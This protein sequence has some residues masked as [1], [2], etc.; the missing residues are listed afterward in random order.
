MDNLHGLI[1]SLTI[2]EFEA[3]RNSYL[4]QEKNNPQVQKTLS[5]LDFLRHLKDVPSKK[6]CIKHVY[7]TSKEDSFR[8]LKSR[9]NQRIL[10]ILIHENNIDK[11]EIEEL[12]IVTIRLRKKFSQV[13]YLYFT[14]GNLPVVYNLLNS[15]I[16]SAEE[17]NI[18]SI[19]I[20][21]LRL[22]KQFVSIRET[23]DVMEEFDNQ[24]SYYQRCDEARH[25]AVDFYCRLVRKV[26]FEGGEKKDKIQALLLDGINEL[27]QLYQE[28]NAPV[29]GYYLKILELA[30]FSNSKNYS[31]AKESCM[32]QLEFLQSKELYRKSRVGMVYD[33]AGQLQILTGNYQE[34][35]EYF[36][37][38]VKHY[39]S[40]SINVV[41]SREQEFFAQFYMGDYNAAM[42]TIS[43]L[44]SKNSDDQGNFRASKFLYY[45]A[46][47]LFQSGDFQQCK[48]IIMQN[49][50]LN[51]DKAGWEVAVRILSIMSNIELGNFDMAS[52]QIISFKKHIERTSKKLLINERDKLI[53][54]L[55]ATLEKSGFV[56][57]E[58]LEKEKESFDALSNPENEPT[59]WKILSPEL[60]PFHKWIAQKFNKRNSSTHR[61]LID[62]E[63]SRLRL[64]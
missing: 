52:L 28:L 46:A 47:L 31:V 56:F 2:S 64:N 33:N 17:Y 35:I 42:E 44:I 20:E 11:L 18:Y 24:I 62:K 1:S 50:E 53:F 57:S 16:K 29:V 38:A 34:A 8:Q 32:E 13:L 41:I 21:A 39:K 19:L 45:K 22:K 43:F 58:L 10:D 36:R 37:E 3:V 9:L 6:D 15:I 27:K 48:K 26:D 4:L 55:L 40:N 59:C 5:L 23:E 25:K 63:D 51:Q 12:D 61:Q 54:K 7:G 60:I 30:Y 14:K 49:L